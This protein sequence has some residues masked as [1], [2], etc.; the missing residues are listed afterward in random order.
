MS[1]PFFY[2][3]WELLIWQWS[4]I[5]AR[6]GLGSICP[7]ISSLPLI[8]LR[9]SC[10][11]STSIRFWFRTLL[12]SSPCPCHSR[13]CTFL[14]N[15]NPFACRT[16]TGNRPYLQWS[17]FVLTAQITALQRLARCIQSCR[18]I[19]LFLI[20]LIRCL[21]S[22]LTGFQFVGFNNLWLQVFM[23]NQIGQYLERPHCNLFLRSP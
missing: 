7:L 15:R 14:Y 3:N 9:L 10:P 13:H 22:Q 2:P 21:K 18:M 17:C 1:L 23:N 20:L 12:L 11:S 4:R 5:L 19:G 16:T 6:L 8:W